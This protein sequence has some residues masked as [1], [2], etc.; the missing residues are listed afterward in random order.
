MKSF[1]IHTLGCPKNQV[2]SD[3]LQ[4]ALLSSGLNRVDN[5]QEADCIFVNTCAFITEAKEE[6]IDSILT[7]AT[8]KGKGQRLIVL[9]CLP[10]RYRDVLEREIPEVDA[11][12]GVQSTGHILGYLNLKLVRSVEHPCPDTFPY[13]YVKVSD[14]CNRGCSF[15]AIP[16]IRGRHRSI[17]PEE[18]LSRAEALLKRNY[19]ELILVS[20]DTSS[21]GRDLKGYRLPELI[22]D[23]TSFSGEYWVRILYLY[24]TSIGD[25]LIEVIAGEQ[26][27]VPYLDIPVQHSV[28]RILR[29]MN[30][31]GSEVQLL[32]LINRL[33]EAIPGVVLRTSIIVGFPTEKEEEFQSLLGFIRKAE[34]DHLGAFKYSREE[35]TK[36]ASLRPQI[37]ERVK[38]ERYQRL[39]AL[40]AEISEQR[41][42]QWKGR[43]VRVLVE[44]AGAEVAVGRFYGQAPEI[45]GAV[46]MEPSA[47]LK[48]GDF[49]D[50][51]ITDT[52]VYDLWGRPL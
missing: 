26:K 7:L 18:I 35:G 37:P 43:V 44:E 25:D 27:V 33:R 28:A 30:R 11:F 17:P 21:Y 29:L 19:K 49:V 2:D 40:Q 41:W 8:Q 51:M 45:D 15:C 50:V 10:Q 52:G 22:R 24:P 4:T 9:G 23:I 34:F 12:F 14:G 42:R 48:R 16:S 3:E 5:P 6:S 38:E 1:Y 13:A 20:Q 32:S 36:A 46:Y 39:M 31:P 47:G